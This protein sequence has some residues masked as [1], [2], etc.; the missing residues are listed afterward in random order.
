VVVIVM[1]VAHRGPDPL[2]ARDFFN[3][4]CHRLQ[5]LAGIVVAQTSAICVMSGYPE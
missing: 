2:I 3:S 4:H 1:L 5:L